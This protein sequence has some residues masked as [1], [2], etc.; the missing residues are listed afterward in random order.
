MLKLVKVSEKHLSAIIQAVKEYKTDTNPYRVAEINNL[1]DAVDHDNILF[2]IK[3]KQN[4]DKG[5]NLNPGYVASTYYLLMEGEEYIGSFQLRHELTERLMNIGGN[6]SYIILPSKRQKGYAF[7]GL[8]LVLSEARK[9][10]LDRVLITCNAKNDASFAVMTKA[11]KKYGGE[12]LPDVEIDDGF[13][14]RV[15]VN[16]VD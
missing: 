7:K 5:I 10:G 2:W 4:E 15:W 12:I 16:T 3:Q 8:R 9:M 1:I 13:E 6:I 11:M 14:H